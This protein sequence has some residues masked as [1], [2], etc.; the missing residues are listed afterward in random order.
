M[1]NQLAACGRR[2]DPVCQTPELDSAISEKLQ[3]VDEICDGPPYPIKL[4]DHQK[5]TFAK[6]F[7]RFGKTGAALSSCCAALPDRG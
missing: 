4:P 6:Q 2:I 1:K 5:I 3:N 7:Q